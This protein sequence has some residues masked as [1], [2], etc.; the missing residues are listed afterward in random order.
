MCIMFRSLVEI[1]FYLLLALCISWSYDY[2]LKCVY[3]VLSCILACFYHQLPKCCMFLN[4]E[5][6]SLPGNSAYCEVFQKFIKL[7]FG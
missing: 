5:E 3:M 1:E 2:V 6:C 7:F 4:L